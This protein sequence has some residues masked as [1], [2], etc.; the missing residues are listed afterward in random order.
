MPPASLSKRLIAL[1]YDAFILTALSMA[2]SALATGAMVALGGAESPNYRPMQNG[3]WFALGW[4]ITLVA[5]YWFFWKRAGQTVGMRAWRLK[6]IS[7]DGKPLSHKQCLLRIVVAPL[8]LGL[9]G[10]G[11]LWCWCNRDKAAWQDIASD[12]RVVMVPKTKDKN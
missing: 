1:V 8:A 4:V 7:N 3:P 12:T 5:F 6:V 2:Y 10:A 11:Y 9:G